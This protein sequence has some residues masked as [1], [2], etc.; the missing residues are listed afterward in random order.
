LVDRWLLP[1]ALCATLH[2]G[3]HLRLS[4]AGSAMFWVWPSFG[5]SGLS[6]DKVGL[7][8][9]G[10]RVSARRPRYF[11]LLRQ[12]KVP[13]EKASRMHCPSLCCGH[14]ALL[15]P[16]GVWLN[17]PSAQTTPALIRAGLRYSPA[18]DGGRREQDRTTLRSPGAMQNRLILF[19]CAA[20]LWGGVPMALGDVGP[21]FRRVAGLSSAAAG[22]SGRTL[23]ERSEFS[24]TPP[25]ASSARYRA[26][27]R[28]SARLSFGYLSLA[29]QRKVPRPPGRDPAYTV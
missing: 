3:Q 28:T 22:G 4:E 27:A 5:S 15:G 19:V 9:D 14:A 10:S 11:L 12:K 18:H 6:I 29:K 20:P 16:R 17:S 7:N 26:A 8:C 21:V 13:K 24:L 23:F 25:D 2:R 1:A